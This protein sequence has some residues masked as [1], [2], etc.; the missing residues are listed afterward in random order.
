MPEVDMIAKRKEWISEISESVDYLF[1]EGIIKI[2]VDDEEKTEASVKKEIMD[3]IKELN[4]V[5]LRDISLGLS[6][7]GDDYL[8]DELSNINDS[9]KPKRKHSV[10]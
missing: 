4:D 9:I 3:Q 6:K 8:L 1:S 5:K 2:D 10:R 7:Y